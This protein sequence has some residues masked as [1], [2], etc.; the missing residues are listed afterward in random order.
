[1]L[2]K[3][4]IHLISENQSIEALNLL[5]N[6]FGRINSE[7]IKD[8]VQLK[9]QVIEIKQE[10]NNDVGDLNEYKRVHN[11]IKDTILQILPSDSDI[12]KI[13]PPL[14]ERLEENKKNCQETDTYFYTTCSLVAILQIPSSSLYRCIEQYKFGS[15]EPFYLFVKNYLH[16]NIL[17][18]P[19]RQPYKDMEWFDREEFKNAINICIETGDPVIDDKKLFLGIIQGNSTTRQL[20]TRFFDLDKLTAIILQ[21]DN[22]NTP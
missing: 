19:K 10:K 21:S 4:V 5:I 2:Q 16:D 17:N 1:M 9:A 15:F 14:M 20:L 18:N 6:F 3:K 8:F 11:R 12:F 13:D 7:L 22:F